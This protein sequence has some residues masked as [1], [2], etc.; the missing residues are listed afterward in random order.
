MQSLE[1]REVDNWDIGDRLTFALAGISRVSAEAVKDS[2]NPIRGFV[3]DYPTRLLE[4]LDF[5]SDQIREI[6]SEI[7]AAKESTN[8]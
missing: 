4:Q 7:A 1:N 3:D 8:E 2:L 5:W 6:E